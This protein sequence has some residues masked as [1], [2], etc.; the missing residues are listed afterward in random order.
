M[1]NWNYYAVD[2][3]LSFISE[4]LD[5]LMVSSSSRIFIMERSGLLVASSSPQQPFVIDPKTNEPQRLNVQNVKDPLIQK[6]AK[7]LL[8]ESNSFDNIQDLKQLKIENKGK[9]IFVGDGF[10]IN[11]IKL[12]IK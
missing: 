3:S 1:N 8:Q 11:N 5:Q 10:I 6:I 7:N 9:H 2:L 12:K 4:F